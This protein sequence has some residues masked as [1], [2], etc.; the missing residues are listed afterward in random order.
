MKLPFVTVSSSACA[1]PPAA[2]ICR[3][4]FETSEWF[5]IPE[6]TL[7]LLLILSFLR[8]WYFIINS[9]GTCFIGLYEAWEVDGHSSGGLGVLFSEK[10]VWRNGI[11]IRMMIYNITF[12]VYL[13]R[14]YM[15]LCLKLSMCYN[16]VI[17][18]MIFAEYILSFQKQSATHSVRNCQKERK[19]QQVQ[20]ECIYRSGHQVRSRG[21]DQ[22]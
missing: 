16:W 2:K 22:R 10:L 1:L 6:W 21:C 12:L 7:L 11:W 3:T 14:Y 4:S 9:S 15:K 13:F 8:P 17:K 5:S 18:I 20:L 19:L